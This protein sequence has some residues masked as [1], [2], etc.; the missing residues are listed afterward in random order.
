[1]WGSVPMPPNAGLSADEAK[2][3]SEWVLRQ[4]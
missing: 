4:K 2:T 1:V 3:L